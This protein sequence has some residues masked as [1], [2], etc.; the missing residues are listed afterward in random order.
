MAQLLPTSLVKGMPF[1]LILVGYLY[2]QRNGKNFNHLIPY[3]IGSGIL[4][5]TYT[6][7][8]FE[9]TIPNLFCFIPL[10][11]YWTKQP[12]ITSKIIK[13]AF[14]CFILLISFPNYLNLFASKNN[15]L[16]GYLA[17]SI[18]FLL[19]P[20]LYHGEFLNNVSNS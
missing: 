4:L 3:L 10:V 1:I 2:L 17:V 13:Y 9:Y 11:F 15:I 12:N 8:A 20:L 19:F 18:I 6:T 14:F 5:L 7:I 16:A